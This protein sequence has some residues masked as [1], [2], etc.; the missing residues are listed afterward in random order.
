MY[1]GAHLETFPLEIKTRSSLGSDEVVS[2]GFF[3][4]TQWSG[5][6]GGLN[7]HFTFPPQYQLWY[8]TNSK[9]DFLTDLPTEK[10]KV[11]KISLTRTSGIRLVIHC[12]NKEVLN[13]VFSDSTCSYVNN[14]NLRWN[15]Y[16]TRDV[17]YI[18]FDTYDSASNYY[19]GRGNF[20]DN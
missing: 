16:W 14:F 11:W 2:V 12:N 8:C 13:F 10:E 6:M 4:S 19:S 5:K 15:A 9:I 18:S 3:Q 1:I 20:M 7:L 17:R